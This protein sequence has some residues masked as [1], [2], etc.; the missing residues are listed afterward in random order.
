MPKRLMHRKVMRP[1][2]LAIVSGF[3]YTTVLTAEQQPITPIPLTVEVNQDKAALGKKLF[4]ETRLSTSNTIS[5]ASCHDLGLGFGTDKKQF[6]EGVDGHIGDRNSPTVY[7][8]VFNFK[9]FWDGRADDLASQAKMPVVNPLEMG[10]SS[11]TEAIAN[12]K[13]DSHYKS[14][15]DSIYAGEMTEDTI[16]DAIAEFEKTLITPNSPFDQFLRGDLN[17]INEEQKKGYSLFKS[18]GCISCHQGKNVGGNMFQK[19][20]VLKDI[21]LQTGNLNEDLGRYQVT[22][23]EWDKRVFKVPSLRLAVKTPPYFHNG[24]VKTIEEAVDIM[25]E[26]QLGRTVPN[27]DRDSIIAFLE[28]LVG[29]IPT[30]V[31]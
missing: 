5:C 12:I 19:I 14:Q 11:W 1:F 26:F 10:M 25:I 27:S 17:A 15:F 2:I 8:A 31:Q 20:G 4:F 23:N 21:S 7:N 13:N 29:E 18:Y 6:S 22:K 28:S 24:S 16:V 9:Q 30:G 3:S